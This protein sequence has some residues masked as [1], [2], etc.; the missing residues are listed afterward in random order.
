MELTLVIADMS[1]S[2]FWTRFRPQ[3]RSTNALS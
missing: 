2:A 1:L 3:T